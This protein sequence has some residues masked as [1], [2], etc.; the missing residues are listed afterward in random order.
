MVVLQESSQKDRDLVTKS[1]EGRLMELRH[2][3]SDLQSKLENSENNTKTAEDLLYKNSEKL[4]LILE[5]KDNDKKILEQK[6]QELTKLQMENAEL[7]NKL[8]LLANQPTAKKQDTVS[9]GLIQLQL[10]LV[11]NEIHYLK[12]EMKFDEY[13]RMIRF[14]EQFKLLEDNQKIMQAQIVSLS[15]SHMEAVRKQGSLRRLERKRRHADIVSPEAS[16]NTKR[17]CTIM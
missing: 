1:Y 11:Q 14:E 8:E 6:T 4:K 10:Q 2:K 7:K 9:D 5:E 17:Y 12:A 15:D 3:I 16:P 13:R